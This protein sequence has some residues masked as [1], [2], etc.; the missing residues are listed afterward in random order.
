MP[1]MPLL[2]FDLT[3]CPL[4]TNSLDAVVLLNVLEHIPDDTAALHQVYRIL[5]PGGVAVIE[6][7]AGPHLYDVYDKLLLHCRRYFLAQ[8]RDLA[9][10]AGFHILYQ[11]HMGFFVYPAFWL[12]KKRNRRYLAEEKTAQEQIVRQNIQSSQQSRL[13]SLLMRTELKLGQ[14][15]SY[16]FGIRCLLTCRKV[17]EPIFELS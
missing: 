6:V 7:P 5:K 12:T 16:P 9:R 4:P 17:P 3:T 10:N 11:S 15:I 2:Q 1:D 13:F 14:Y 8:A